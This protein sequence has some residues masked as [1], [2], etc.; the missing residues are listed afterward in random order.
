MFFGRKIN[1]SYKL[2]KKLV[3]LVPYDP[4]TGHYDIRLDANES[5]FELAPELKEKVCR[6]IPTDCHTSVR[7]GSQ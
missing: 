3:N 7:T 1:M 4:I 5:Y 2:N 6:S